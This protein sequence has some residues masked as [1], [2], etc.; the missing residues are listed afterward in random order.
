[1][2]TIDNK[3][4][5]YATTAVEILT[6]KW[7]TPSTPVQWIPND[8]W[9][10]PTICMELVDYM[11][12]AGTNTY[13]STI[14]ATQQAGQG[15][16]T[17]C[18]YLDDAT[19]WGRLFGMTYQWLMNGGSGL[20]PK[21]YLNDAILVFNNLAGTWNDQCAGGLF[22]QRPPGGANN[23]KATNATL[24]LMEI[25]LDLYNATGTQSY[26]DW[27]QKAWGWI[28]ARKLIDDQGMVWGGLTP[29]GAQPAC[30]IDPH[31]VP[32]VALQG[33]PLGPMWDLYVITRDTSLLDTAETIIEGTFQNMTW[34]DSAIL[35][36]PVDSEW[37][38][39]T[40]SWRQSNSGK[41]P[42]KGIFSAFCGQFVADLATV[43]GREAKAAQYAA[44]LRDN[45]D[46][47]WNNYP[48]NH[49]F[50][51]NW[52]AS[53]PDYQGDSNDQ[54][55]ACLQYSALAIFLAAAKVI[56]L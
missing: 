34:P 52:D 38:S 43:S 33:N 56:H 3:Y 20:D 12:F 45:A 54:I 40:E 7:F 19:C 47:L 41:T 50:D 35:M 16:L 49:I 5:D 24:G 30:V 53:A 42:F 26:L 46:T 17:N 25:G 51:M 44:Q 22:W 15:W 8:Y 14:Q 36:T 37:A 11:G 28:V 2:T 55:N 31:N 13:A 32:V 21:V 39:Q 48:T 10:A 18:G 9:R 23:V 27:A 1:M 4:F 29:P 6:S